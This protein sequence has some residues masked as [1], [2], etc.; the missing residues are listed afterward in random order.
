MH[1]H[2][3]LFSNRNLEFKIRDSME[4]LEEISLQALFSMNDS[5]LE[6]LSIQPADESST[7]ATNLRL[8]L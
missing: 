7:L 8:A 1:R 5:D 2:Q 6:I 4:A 3:E